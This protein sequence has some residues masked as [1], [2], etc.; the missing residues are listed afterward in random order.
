VQS[1]GYAEQQRS[2]KTVA[3]VFDELDKLNLAHSELY[4]NFD[5]EQCSADVWT[6][7]KSEQGTV[8]HVSG[9]EPWIFILC[10][11]AL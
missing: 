8:V 10:C 2:A 6:T 9:D 5:K 7:T 1:D 11:K 3:T 4:W